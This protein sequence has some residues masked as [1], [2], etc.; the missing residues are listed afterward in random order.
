ML[1]RTA[2]EHLAGRHVQGREQ[3][4]GAVADVVVGPPLRLAEIH[5]QKRLRMLERLNLRLF[6]H[7]EHDGVCR[8]GHVQADASRGLALD[9]TCDAP[10]SKTATKRLLEILGTSVNALLLTLC[11]RRRA[12]FARW[13]S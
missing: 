10:Q 4:E 3:I 5:R 11:D 8:R 9:T 1:R 7:R 6:V 12:A 2:R 13:K